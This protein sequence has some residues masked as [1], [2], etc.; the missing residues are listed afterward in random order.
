[1]PHSVAVLIRK[2]PL[3]THLRME[4]EKFCHLLGSKSKF[5]QNEKSVKMNKT[6]LKK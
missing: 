5:M 2:T 3:V 4:N 1:M 6:C